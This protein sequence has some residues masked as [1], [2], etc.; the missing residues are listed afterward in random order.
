MEVNGT[1]VLTT[2]DVSDIKNQFTVGDSLHF[3]IWRSGQV[4]EFDVRLMENNDVY[5]G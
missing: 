5:G 4:L 1:P 2:A 3:T